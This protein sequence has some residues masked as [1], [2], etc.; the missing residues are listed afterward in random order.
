MMAAAGKVRSHL[1]DAIEGL[2]LTIGE[3]GKAK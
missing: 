2:E 1:V 3:K